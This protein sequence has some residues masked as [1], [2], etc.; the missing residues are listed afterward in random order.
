[1]LKGRMLKQRAHGSCWN[2]EISTKT[3]APCSSP[4]PRAGAITHVLGVLHGVDEHVAVQHVH[5]EV[6]A[7]AREAARERIKGTAWS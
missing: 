2:L 4:A 3:R 7:L 6:V 1:M 5:I